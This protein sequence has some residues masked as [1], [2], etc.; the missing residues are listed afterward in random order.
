MIVRIPKHR[1]FVIT[2][3]EKE[4]RQEECWDKLQQIVTDYEKEGKSVYTPTFIEDNEE[5][6][7]ELQKEYSFTYT[8]ELK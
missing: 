8:I 2:I 6:V 1:E 5:K 7:K 4:T 3:D